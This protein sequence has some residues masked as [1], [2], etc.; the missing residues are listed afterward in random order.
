MSK[1]EV[2]LKHARN[3]INKELGLEAISI[4]DSDSLKDQSQ[5]VFVTIYN[6]QDHL[7]GCIG[8][9]AP[10]FSSIGEEIES[11]AIASAF[12]DP[13]FNPVQAKE[14]NDLRLEISLLEPETPIQSIEEL[15]PK[16][17][18]II[19]TSGKRRGVLLPDIDG[20]DSV[21]EQIRITLQKAGVSPSEDYSIEKFLVKKLK[22]S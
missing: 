17:F 9:I 6:Q 15:D 19:I 16:K 22:E 13:R 8:H 1:D 20:V 3:S 4:S 14:F 18:G 12:Q 7:R 21:E 5:G 10:A 11:V 2:L